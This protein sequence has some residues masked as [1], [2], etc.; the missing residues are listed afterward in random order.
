MKSSSFSDK[1]ASYVVAGRLGNLSERFLRILAQ[2]GAKSIITFSRRD[3]GHDEYGHLQST[4]EVF[5]PGCRLHCIKCDVTSQNAL[6]E[7]GRLITSMGL[8]PVRGVIQ[9]AAVISLS[10]FYHRTS[11]V[12]CS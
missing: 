5:Q 1:E 4:F 2:R 10:P 12:M 6:D 7:A 8:P 3:A 9:Y 11:I